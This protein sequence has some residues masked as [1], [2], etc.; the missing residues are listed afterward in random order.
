VELFFSVSGGNV[1]ILDNT[2]SPLENDES[3]DIADIAA[4]HLVKPV[5]EAY[6]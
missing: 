5:L 2:G 3:A 1:P 6:V 4:K